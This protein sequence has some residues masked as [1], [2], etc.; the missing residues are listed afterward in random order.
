MIQGQLNHSDAA[1]YIRQLKDHIDELK[2]E[3]RHPW[4]LWHR[5]GCAHRGCGPCILCL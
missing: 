4:V 5:K 3:V 2:A 1:Q